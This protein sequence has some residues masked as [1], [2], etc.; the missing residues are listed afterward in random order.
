M[1]CV[2]STIFSSVLIHSSPHA[3]VSAE[4][5]RPQPIH[6]IVGILAAIV[7]LLLLRV[8]GSYMRGVP[9]VRSIACPIARVATLMTI[10]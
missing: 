7:V 2:Y 3:F 5:D 4:G 10:D 6:D 8:S 1:S 9:E